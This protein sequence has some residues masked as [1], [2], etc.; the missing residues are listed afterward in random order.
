MTLN[1]LYERYLSEL[2]E[3]YALKFKE[4]AED[5]LK[6]YYNKFHEIRMVLGE[7]VKAEPI[8]FFIVGTTPDCH[9]ACD[10][11]ICRTYI[12]PKYRRKGIMYRE[13]SDFLKWHKGKYCLDVID[14]NPAL[15]FWE[16][17]FASCGYQRIYMKDVEHGIGDNAKTY[18]WW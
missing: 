2:S 7:G 4:S 13:I 3:S 10:Y 5:I 11:Y 14:G 12:L 1:E 8:G 18:Y 6:N 15:K 17:V 16:K 9:P